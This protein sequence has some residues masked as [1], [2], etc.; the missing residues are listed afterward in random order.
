MFFRYVGKSGVEA[1]LQQPRDLQLGRLLLRSHVEVV[2]LVDGDDADV[3]QLRRFRR[4][5]ICRRVGAVR[6]RVHRQGYEQVSL[7]VVISL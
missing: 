7:V 1:L 4:D 6:G 2:L 5:A 3:Q